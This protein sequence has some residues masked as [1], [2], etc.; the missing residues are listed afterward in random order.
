[1]S[2]VL[3]VKDLRTQFIEQA[4]CLD[5]KLDIDCTVLAELQE[6]YRRRAVVEQEYADTLVK[7][8]NGLKQR[9]VN[10]TSK[11]PHWAPYTTTTIL[12]TLLG[13]TLRVSEAHALLSDLFAKQM[14]QRL[15]DM[16][17]DAVRLH[18][19]CR[20]MMSACQ[21][22]V[23]ASTA[24]LQQ[25]Q[26]EYGTK[27]LTALEADRQRRRAEEKV[28][29]AAQ[30]AKS[31]NKD[32]KSS[33]RFLRA[34]NE[35]S[36]KD[37]T[38]TGTMIATARARNDYLVQLA[39]T[40]HSISRYFAEEA[41][42]IIDCL[43]CGFHNSL[44]RSAMMHLS[45]EEALKTCHSSIV[46][47]FNRTVTAL[48]W[49]QDKACFLKCNEHSYTRP[50][51]FVFMPAKEDS[52][53]QIQID[54][55]LRDQLEMNAK[56]LSAE[57]EALRISTEETWKTLEVVEKRL[58][59]LINQKDYDV[60]RLFITERPRH[61]RSIGTPSSNANGLLGPTGSVSAAGSSSS[62]V[63]IGTSSGGSV[64]QPD[65]SLGRSQSSHSPS[66]NR[67]AADD[68]S[69]GLYLR[70]RAAHRN[71]RIEQEK[72]YLDVSL[73]SCIAF[74]LM[75]LSN[76]A[77]ADD[78]SSGLYLRLRAAHR[79]G[80][81]EQ[82]KFYLDCF[83][84]YTE[85]MHKCQMLQVKL[86]E[87]RRALEYDSKGD[88]PSRS[89]CA[90]AA[91]STPTA[92][93]YGWH[94]LPSSI[95][96][97]G[98]T[99]SV[100][101][102]RSPA[103]SRPFTANKAEDSFASSSP[104]PPPAPPVPQGKKVIGLTRNK[105][106]LKAV[107]GPPPHLH[108]ASPSAGHP[109]G[110]PLNSHCAALVH[111]PPTNR[112][113]LAGSE[114]TK[115]PIPSILV[116]CT[117]VIVQFGLHQQGIFRVSG[118]QNEINEFK[119]AF[120]Q[121]EDP[122]V[123]VREAREI[124]STA[125]LLKL[126]FRE[127]G[128][129]P[130]PNTMFANLMACAH[131]SSDVDDAAR[132]LR[133]VVCQGL[134]RPVFIVMR[135]LFAFLSHV[136]EHADENSMDAYNLAICFAP[137]LMAVPGELNQVHYHSSVIDLIKTFITHH[138]LVFDPLVPGPMYSK[139][140]LPTSVLCSDGSPINTSISF[141]GT[142]SS[143]TVIRDELQLNTVHRTTPTVV[144]T[145]I[146]PP[147]S[148]DSH[149]PNPRD[150]NI[151]ITTKSSSLGTGKKTTEVLDTKD[152]GSDEDEDEDEEEEDDYEVEDTRSLDDLLDSSVSQQLEANIRTTDDMLQDSDANLADLLSSDG[153]L[154]DDPM[155]GTVFPLTVSCLDQDQKVSTAPNGCSSSTDIDDDLTSAPKDLSNPHSDDLP[156]PTDLS[157]IPLCKSD[158]RQGS[159]SASIRHTIAI[160]TCRGSLDTVP[161]D[162]A[163][164]T[165]NSNS[166]TLHCSPSHRQFSPME[167]NTSGENGMQS[168]FFSNADIDNQ[169]A[170]FMRNLSSLEQEV[171]RGSDFLSIERTREL[172]RKFQLPSA[173]HTP[174]LVMDLP[175]TKP[176]HAPG[177]TVSSTIIP[178]QFDGSSADKFAEQGLDTM[179]KR[180]DSRP[181]CADP[182]ASV[183]NIPGSGAR[184]VSSCGSAK[185][186]HS[187]VE[188]SSV[189]ERRNSPHGSDRSL[190][191]P[192]T[193]FR[194]AS[195]AA[196]VAAFEAS[197]SPS[198]VSFGRGA[199][200]P[201]LAPKPRRAYDFADTDRSLEQTSLRDNEDNNPTDKF[202]D[203]SGDDLQSISDS[204]LS[205]TPY[206]VAVAQ[207]DFNG[208]TMRELSFQ[209]GDELFLY[210]RLNDHWWEGQLATD[211]S[212]VRGLVPNLYVVPKATLK[213]TEVL[214]TK[215]DG[216]DED[217]DEDEEEEDD[218]E[219]E[220]TRSLDD[221]LDSSVSQ[222][223]EANIRTTDDMLQDSDAN[224][225]DLLSSDG[226]LQDDPMLGTV[227][228]LTVSCLDQD[229][230]VSTAPNGCSSSTD[231][232]DD[233]TSAPKDLSNPHSD[234]LPSP[235]DLSHIPL[236]KS[237]MRQGSRSAS[238]RHTI[239]I[240]TCRGS[241]DTVPE[242]EAMTTANSNSTTLHCSPSHRQFSP[243]ETNTSGE[244]GMQS[245]F[246]SNADIDNQLA[247]FMRNLSSLEQEVTRGSDF[248]SIERTR[249]LGRKFQL[250]SAK[251]TPDL[252]M[253]LPRTK[254]IHAPGS[255]VS[256]TIIPSQFDGSSADKFAEQ[257]LDT[258][259]K[260]PDSRPE[261]ADPAASV[262]NTPGSGAR[263]VSSFQCLSGRNSPHGSDRS[264]SPPETGFRTA[265]IAARVAAFEA[266]SSPSDVS[267]G[268]GAPRPPLAPKPRRA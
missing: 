101:A 176:I 267:F 264:L 14:V 144:D 3:T 126:Y 183:D 15:V 11:R 266:S 137:S 37:L 180:P 181:E 261:C 194:T 221:L 157:H 40:N 6:F 177:S 245:R 231:I 27:Q 196:R 185:S 136:A 9:H 29:L 102:S 202:G 198:D 156:S 117:R 113:V 124:N 99:S 5:L 204:D 127:L 140:A 111:K 240:P 25:D 92:P 42:D 147:P 179:R 224:L 159:R 90:A 125:G 54:G 97:L 16:D 199:P 23:L 173:K 158:M 120:E 63:P 146:R 217:E 119:A 105:V 229:Q 78:S 191:P 106:N 57:I 36:S 67:A 230:K 268:R 242:D 251:H 165:A 225:A 48:D 38:Y 82:E 215:D 134:S 149:K 66:S 26:R 51:P 7:L 244:N 248:L 188:T 13:S 32:P 145:T 214:D 96:P 241:L 133:A 91:T 138:S 1:M 62:L 216:S 162:E 258:M 151:S 212:G 70:L 243:M 171:T 213:T 79:N 71:G 24:K 115:Q 8:A 10:E 83:L 132:R 203:Q 207:A 187:S 227:F 87:I 46:E 33:Q 2:R 167:T 206:T 135:F 150:S 114:C 107:G 74:N 172:G 12:N 262:D 263:C 192:E 128:E 174:D 68:S 41:P 95:T 257:G 45:C 58:L 197:S 226:D 109:V 259:R 110:D 104:P 218:Y 69:S 17:E 205:E 73:Q 141:S 77:A 142:N 75:I 233:L 86:A 178:S 93:K 265:S 85:E 239:A 56:Q 235:T 4:K 168:R 103:Q 39:A 247:E 195:I 98:D 152:D 89:L 234:D 81:I 61:R 237:D 164:T 122:L 219:V 222:Q 28:Q 43:A 209:Q 112:R 30:K 211:P 72:F 18:K 184:C 163:M 108:R 80:R 44:A 35:F 130:F 34:Q 238:I 84:R 148:L 123:D 260:R 170:E 118:S 50:N 88:K 19:Q 201:P 175:R 116:S 252:V 22:R 94:V 193:G 131:E 49:R 64:E 100:S 189:F 31:K 256:S 47:M 246:F 220:D 223:L 76:R 255:T 182:A 60:S 65:S 129:P 228:P 154:Q 169:L 208:S 20:E 155:L 121:G 166:T 186:D 143:R 160:P 250:P 139:H 190:S 200:R 153:D 161:E 253:D 21:E 249:E 254:P 210:R 52:E 232:D 236:C 59:E 53:S 55:V